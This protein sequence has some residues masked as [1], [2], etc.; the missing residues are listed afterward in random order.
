MCL[1]L[2]WYNE[3]NTIDW[4]I[5]ITQTHFGK[6]KAIEI[7]LF[8]LE[9]EW[10]KVEI[11]NYGATL[12]SIFFKPLKRE[13][14]LGLKS[15]EDYRLQPFYLGAM[16]GRVA[17]RIDRGHFTLN[18]TAYTLPLNGTHHLHGGPIGFDQRIFDCTIKD[19]VLLCSLVSEDGDQG[20]PGTLTLDLKYTLD[21]ASLKIETSA[22]CDQ[23][24][25]FDATQ[26]TYF[27]LNDDKSQTIL[28]HTLKLNSHALYE[29]EENQCTGPH[30]LDT[31]QTCFDFSENKKI[32]LAM[33]F[34]HPQI[35]RV[36]G[37]DHY[38]IKHQLSDPF[39]AQL[40]SDHLQCSVLT[41]HDGAHI[42]SGNFLKPLDNQTS[43]PGLTAYGGICF[44]TQHVPNSINFDLKR[45]PILRANTCVHSTTIYTYTQGEPDENKN[46]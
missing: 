1:N 36:Q 32:E 26:H 34:A 41:T 35:Q 25:L 38:F 10:L 37:I 24:T 33:D 17:N 3:I 44:E 8:S 19:D 21:G 13:T 31:N 43:P 28:N 7:S 45:A 15:I 46:L 39:F 9:N 16:V 40:T 42:Y 23:D 29:I 4:W 2:G 30:V 20:Y 18:K 14:I 5:M 6:F 22:K 12:K 11:M 27:N